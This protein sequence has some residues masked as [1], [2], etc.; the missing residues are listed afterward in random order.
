MDRVAIAKGQLSF[1]AEYVQECIS[2]LWQPSGNRQNIA[3]LL[4]RMQD[5][6]VL[7]FQLQE[8][9][10]PWTGN[11]LDYEEVYDRACNLV[12]EM[13][14]AIREVF[15]GIQAFDEVKIA[16]E[17]AFLSGANDTWLNSEDE[18]EYDSEDLWFYTCGRLAASIFFAVCP[19]KEQDTRP[20]FS[21]FYDAFWAGVLG[22]GLPEE[23][24]RREPAG[25]NLI[26]QLKYNDLPC[27]EGMTKEE[28][29]DA[30]E[31]SDRARD[32][33]DTIS[34]GLVADG[35]IDGIRFEREF[36]S[37]SAFEEEDQEYG[38]EGTQ[39]EGKYRQKNINIQGADDYE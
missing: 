28:A 36:V 27:H 34:L 26:R 31:R 23:G 11:P 9:Q 19:E 32:E 15:L 16:F 17:Q 7:S 30:L 13:G 25:Q 39:I 8:K 22:T 10:R 35:V 18:E 33:S 6:E 12:W 2:L 1:S 14:Y 5:D 21:G 29:L 3:T 20:S 37:L 4:S 24:W 38:N